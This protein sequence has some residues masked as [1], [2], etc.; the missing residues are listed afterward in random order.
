[1]RGADRD[2]GAFVLSENDFLVPQRQLARSV[3]DR[4]VLTAVVMDLQ[5]DALPRIDDDTLDLV[6]VTLRQRRIFAPRAVHRDVFVGL[7]A[8]V[9]LQLRDDL[10]D[11]LR[12]AFLR[13]EKHVR[14]I[15]HEQIRKMH[16]DHEP[17]VAENHRIFA[18]IR[19][20]FK[21]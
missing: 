17:L 12:R 7:A 5:A 16:P 4:P 11:F 13:H 14:R 18:V 1:M 2:I 20:A 19:A 3:D 21:K 15:D 8:L 6:A 9:L 10:A